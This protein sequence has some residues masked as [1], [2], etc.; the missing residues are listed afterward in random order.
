MT[1]LVGIFSLA[2]LVLGIFVLGGAL[3]VLLWYFLS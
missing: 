2:F 1:A 3:V